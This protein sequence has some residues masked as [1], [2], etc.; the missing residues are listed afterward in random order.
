MAE[1]DPRIDSTAEIIRHANTYHRF[2]LG[3]KWAMI[4]MASLISFLVVAFATNAGLLGGLV[5][6]IVA[7]LI[8]VWAMRH[9]LNHSSDEEVVP[10]WIGRPFRR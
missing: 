4:T 2:M 1:P 5:V 7:F 3:V 9:G 6:G 10:V 8:G